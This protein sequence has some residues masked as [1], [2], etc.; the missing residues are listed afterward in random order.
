MPSAPQARRVLRFGEFQLDVQSAELRK[1]GV[2]VRLPDQPF[3]L[4]LLLIE[5]AGEVVT[6][7]ELRDTLW[8]AGTFV[9]FD[10]GL[11]SIVRKLRDTL[12]DSAEHPGFIETLPRRGYRFIASVTP[13]APQPGARPTAT[14]GSRVRMAW[15]GG[16]LLVAAA[17]G[18]LALAVGGGWPDGVRADAVTTGPGSPAVRDSLAPGAIDPAANEAYLKGVA[19]GGGQTYEALRNAVAY[20]EDAVAKQPDFAMAHASLGSSQLQFLYVGP[21]SPREAVPKAEA[22]TRKALQLDDTLP[23]AHRTLATILGT[24]YWKWDEAGKEVLRA[25]ALSKSPSEIPAAELLQSGQFALAI[26][27][28]ERGRRVDPLSFAAA[29][30]LASAFRAARQY[31]RAIAEYRNALAITPGRPRG[32]FQLG[33]TFVFM[34]RFEEAIHELETAVNLS[35]GNSRFEAYL[36]YAYAAAG[37]PLDARRIVKELEARARQQ[38]VS[39]FG[40]ALIYDALGE[41]EAALAAFERAYQDRAVEFA[42]LDQYPPFKTI[43]TDPRYQSRMREIGPP[44]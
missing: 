13:V 19:A 14:A 26:A 38:Y 16:G 41:K 8:G 39:G 2:T 29:V 34:R 27:H 31:D 18:T 10:T 5:R 4:L 7:E 20:F 32:H 44:R 35:S 25:R 33:V 9:D 21:L 37:R 28:A 12:E 17:I 11:N 3:R 42:Q 30:D 22:A 36:A 43:V 6:R 15:I 1:A 24:Y 23:L 40:L